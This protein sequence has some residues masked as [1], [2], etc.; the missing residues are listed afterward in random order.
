VIVGILLIAGGVI[1]VLVRR[2]SKEIDPTSGGPV[3]PPQTPMQ[4]P[5]QAPAPQTYSPDQS[6]SNFN[7]P[8]DQYVNNQPNP[9][10]SQQ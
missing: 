6:Q 4:P 3:M 9:P 2:Q 10:N 8:Y 5:Y 7:T 1:L